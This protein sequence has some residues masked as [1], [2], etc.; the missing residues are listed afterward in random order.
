M[1]KAELH[2]CANIPT[3]SGC[4]ACTHPGLCRPARKPKRTD[5]REIFADLLGLPAIFPDGD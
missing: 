5:L 3:G 4:G 2:N 1:Y